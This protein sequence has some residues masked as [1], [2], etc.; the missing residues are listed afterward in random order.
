[1]AKAPTCEDQ[2]DNFLTKFKK[3]PDD[4]TLQ[5]AETDDDFEQMVNADVYKDCSKWFKTITGKRSI[6][7]ANQLKLLF[8]IKKNIVRACNSTDESIQKSDICKLYASWRKVEQ[9][10]ENNTLPPNVTAILEYVLEE[11]DICKLL[12][13]LVKRG[14]KN[15]PLEFGYYQQKKSGVVQS[16]AI[17]R[18]SGLAMPSLYYDTLKQAIQKEVTPEF[19]NII[20]QNQTEKVVGADFFEILQDKYKCHIQ[21]MLALYNESAHRSLSVDE[22]MA[23]EIFG[24]EKTFAEKHPRPEVKNQ[25]NAEIWKISTGDE[26]P[27]FASKIFKACITKDDEKQDHT[28]DVYFTTGS[29]EIAQVICNYENDAKQKKIMR[30]YLVLRVLEHFSILV[31]P[32]SFKTLYQEFYEKSLRG[33]HLTYSDQ[34]YLLDFCTKQIPDA[35]IPIIKNFEQGWIQSCHTRMQNLVNRL[36]QTAMKYYKEICKTDKAEEIIQKI[37]FK[38]GMPEQ[39]T[40][41]WSLYELDEDKHLADHME[42][43]AMHKHRKK[44][45]IIT[46]K[47]A[48]THMEDDMA[49][50]VCNACFNPADGDFGSITITF[51]MCTEEWTDLFDGF[52]SMCIIAHEISHRF[53]THNKIAMGL[54]PE[55]D[56]LASE[57]Q[58]S[59]YT[60]WKENCWHGSVNISDDLKSGEMF[61]DTS[62][63]DI[64][65]SEQM[66]NVSISA[67][68]AAKAEA[69]TKQCKKKWVRMWATQ[70]SPECMLLEATTDAHPIGYTR[71]MLV[72]LQ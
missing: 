11:Q 7:A 70:L 19:L 27:A 3:L 72:L 29:Q 71:S 33:V 6:F 37:Q 38:I 53:D 15:I 50:D 63:F 58:A 60:H 12:A 35:L 10:R 62:G 13:Y 65:V 28:C 48:P 17:I 67:N 20:N 5:M 18:P 2:L 68:G 54:T 64:A 25:G 21:N 8:R 56:Q 1:M 36:K 34:M 45:E 41:N 66:S 40:D 46:A 44:V 49:W 43:I 69:I 39:G 26:E 31:M 22:D 9:T 23:R 30:Y 16:N 42:K 4:K 61:A 55:A 14:I 32:E 57:V 47:T 51:A 59:N 52:A 24:L